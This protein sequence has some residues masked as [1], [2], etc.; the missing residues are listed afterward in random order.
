MASDVNLLSEAG[1]HILRS[2]GKRIRPRVTLQSSKAVG[3][4]ATP[5]VISVAV[6]VEMLH[7]ASLIHDDINDHGDTRRGQV[8]VNAR[9]GNSMALLVGDFVFVRVLNVIA[10]LGSDV[11]QIIAD[12]CTTLVEGETLQL[13]HRG[14]CDMTEKSYLEI[15]ARKTGG[16][17][18]ASA[19][20]GALVAGGSA[21]QIAA[22][23]EYGLNLGIAFQIRDDTLD[24][25]STRDR[26][27]KPVQSDLDLGTMSLA[28]IWALQRSEAVR[29]ILL[30]RD[31]SQLVGLLRDTGALEYAMDKAMEYAGRGKEALAVLPDSA[32]KTELCDLADFAV[33][34]SR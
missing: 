4:R 5:Q 8:T 6:A 22:L 30:S 27:G 29:G 19:A 17:F 18:S 21:D 1:K 33:G 16:L 15:V 9:W 11:V 10:G 3:G 7:T 28:T 14:D 25:V 23:E 26:L 34:R 12:C 20:L 32:A 31:V 13:L 2:G 24:L